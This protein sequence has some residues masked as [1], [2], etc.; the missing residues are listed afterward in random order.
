M[1]KCEICNR[2]SFKKIRYGGYTL[3]SKHMHQLRKY[4]KFLDNNPRT[5]NDLNDYIIKNDIAIFN[6]YNR[7]NEKVG[8]F[9]ID[10]EDISKVKYKKWRL[11]HGRVVTGN[12]TKKHPTKHLSHII[13]NIDS[14][15]Y[16]HKIDHFD[17]NPLN[18]RKNNLRVCNQHENTL[19]KA[20]VSNNTSGF[21]GV[22]KDKRANRTACWGAEIRFHNKRTHIGSYKYIEEAVYARYIAECILF[23]E[24]R[25]TNTD[26]IKFELFKT[27][28][29]KRKDDI[30]QYVTNKVSTQ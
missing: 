25:N 10:K 21:I 27:I 5:N 9:I 6:L 15:D 12:N 18:N 24:F 2:E 19:N 14:T 20:R 28:P 8:E 13:L 29:N 30:K 17:G 7:Q 11:S 16:E 4:G 1:Y 22:S 26:D 23:K 3:C